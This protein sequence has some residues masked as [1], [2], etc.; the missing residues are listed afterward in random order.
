LTRKELRREWN[1]N[2][3][4]RKGYARDLLNTLERETEIEPATSSSG[5][6]LSIENKE[7]SVYGVDRCPYRAPASK[8]LSPASNESPQSRLARRR[9]APPPGLFVISKHDKKILTNDNHEIKMK[10]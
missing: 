2:G 6:W 10:I 9:L 7:Y 5:N 1:G 3:T 4:D 8:K